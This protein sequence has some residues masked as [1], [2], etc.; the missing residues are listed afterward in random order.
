MVKDIFVNTSGGAFTATLP[1]SPTA[2]AIVAFKD[3]APS[4]ATYNLTIG[5]NSSNIQGNAND[6]RLL[7]TDRAS[8]VLVYM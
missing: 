4:F 2:G 7:S 8:V 5:R 1:S 3:Y 6:S